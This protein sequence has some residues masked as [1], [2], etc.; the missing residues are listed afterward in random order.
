MARRARA[1]QWYAGLAVVLALPTM[2][3]AQAN[4][5]DRVEAV[6]RAVFS[7]SERGELSALDSLYTA[8]ATIIEGAGLDR[9][10]VNYRDH[11]LAPE[12]K[13]FRDF[14]YRP[15]DVEV[16]VHGDVAWVMFRYT[17]AATLGERRIDNVGRGTM[18]LQRD[19]GAWRIRHSHT[20]SRA[21]RA[22]DAP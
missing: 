4:E 19:R 22:S 17:L 3:Q 5:R 13:E 12:L 18:I 16:S 7:A 14:R 2:V 15:S 20:S 11:H 21:R 9:S 1:W 10:W 8:D 6:V